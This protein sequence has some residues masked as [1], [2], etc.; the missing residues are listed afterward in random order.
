[1]NGYSSADPA[2]TM[3]M[4]GRFYDKSDAGRAGTHATALPPKP[5]SS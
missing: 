5:H 2:E 1:M 4:L 3:A